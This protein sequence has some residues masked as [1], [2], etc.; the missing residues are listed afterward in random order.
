MNFDIA[1]FY[2]DWRIILPEAF[3]IVWACVVCAV[4]VL[5][6]AESEKRSG[7]FAVWTLIGAVVTAIWVALT[8]DGAAFGGTFV[9][10]RMALLFKEIVLG[11]VI[12][13]AI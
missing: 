1:Q 3:L 5:G 4:A 12:L 7:T 11:G 9:F 8:P 10:D 2:A 6:K 13:T